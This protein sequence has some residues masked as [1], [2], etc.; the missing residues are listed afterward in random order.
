M[1]DPGAAAIESVEQKIE[2]EELIIRTEQKVQTTSKLSSFCKMLKQAKKQVDNL[3]KISPYLKQMSQYKGIM[4]QILNLSAAI[5]EMQKEVRRKR[6]FRSDEI[7]MVRLVYTSISKDLVEILKDTKNIFLASNKL[8]MLDGSRIKLLEAQKK[9][10]Q[11]LNSVAYSVNS[12]LG[13]ES[14]RRYNMYEELKQISQK[15]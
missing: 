12:I 15:N 10:L 9:K 11:E 6:N 14:A 13:A 3:N 8:N 2:A 4:E 1:Y 5:D 7:K